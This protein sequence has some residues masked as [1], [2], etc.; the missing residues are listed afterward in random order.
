MAV[1]ITSNTFSETPYITVAEYKNAP[2]SIDY[3]NLVVGGNAQAQDAELSNVIR[4]ASSFMDEY[5][6]ANLNATQYVETQRT[7]YF[8][9]KFTIW[10]KP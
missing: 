8:F 3:D 7:Y 4:R 6:N 5:F 1:G 10:H 2:T 9:I